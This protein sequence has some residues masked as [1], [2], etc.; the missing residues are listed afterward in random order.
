MIYDQQP[1]L[2]NDSSE[3]RKVVRLEPKVAREFVV[4]HHYSHGMSA[5]PTCY[6]MVEDGELVG[7][8]VFATPIAE[9]VCS[10]IFGLEHKR[11]VKELHRLVLLD[12][13]GKNAESWFIARAL[14]MFKS[15]RPDFWAVVSFAD[16]TQGHVGTIYQATNA[17]Y[18][19]TTSKRT[20]YSDGDRLRPRRQNGVDLSFEEMETRGWKPMKRNVKHRYLFLLPDN[21]TH[22]KELLKL[23]QVEPQD[24]PK[25]NC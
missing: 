1:T 16:S 14:K 11:R 10:L 18:Y 19:G 17:I 7:V 4:K 13:V 20:F 12:S 6:G 3:G 2:F 8:C 24:Y 23:L 9:S 21:K 5:G 25:A 15:D 22:K